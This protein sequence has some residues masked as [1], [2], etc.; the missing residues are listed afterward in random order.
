MTPIGPAR[1]DVGYR[2]NRRHG[3][4]DPDHGQLFAYHLTVGEAF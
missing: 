1:L 2:L 4:L 3:P